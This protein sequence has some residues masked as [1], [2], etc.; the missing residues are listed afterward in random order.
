MLIAARGNV[1]KS[2]LENSSET[3]LRMPLAESFPAFER[4]IVAPTGFFSKHV[5]IGSSTCAL[6]TNSAVGLIDIVAGRSNTEAV[7]MRIIRV[8]DAL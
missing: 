4:V 7:E 3:V 2:E 6:W 5:S 1:K 8:R